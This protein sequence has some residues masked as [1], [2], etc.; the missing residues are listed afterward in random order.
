MHDIAIS[1]CNSFGDWCCLCTKSKEI[2]NS[3]LHTNIND[4]T[5]NNTTTTT[6]D[7][8]NRYNNNNNA[9]TNSTSVQC[10][11][12]INEK[13]QLLWILS[14]SCSLVNST[15]IIND[16]DNNT[17]DYDYYHR[18]QCF[19]KSLD[20]SDITKDYINDYNYDISSLLLYSSLS[21]NDGIIMN[22]FIISFLT[23]TI[24]IYLLVIKF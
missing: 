3:C 21:Y 4:T 10:N 1:S 20:L 19:N 13:E 14:T 6:T 22:S 18:F 9:N 11:T 8:N 7:N 5:T 15:A 17:S 2:I 16:N 23:I 24:I 12:I